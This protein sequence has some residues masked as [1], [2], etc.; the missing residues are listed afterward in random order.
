MKKYLFMIFFS[1]FFLTG[2]TMKYDI[3]ITEDSVKENINLNINKSNISQSNYEELIN[4]KNPVYLNSDEYYKVEVEENKANLNVHYSYTHNINNFNNSRAIKWCYEDVNFY[5]EDNIIKFFTGEIFNC[6]H[7]K[8]KNRV[9]S[10]QIN[11]TT[12]L[13]VLENN[14]DEVSGNTYTWNINSQ[15]YTNKPI[16]IEMET[17]NSV[18]VS[19][20][21]K[22]F[23]CVISLVT[24]ILIVGLF[25][26]LNYKK[27]N[28]I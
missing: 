7:E 26:K 10:A 6:A 19:F 9:T 2:C 13:K 22:L 14:A 25:M 15:N 3:E 28:A 21:K 8:S 20:T 12:N 17:K 4:E 5:Q 11:I 24:I 23:I 1:L 27:N 16:Y 18:A